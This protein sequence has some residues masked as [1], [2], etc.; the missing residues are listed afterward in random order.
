MVAASTS[1]VKPPTRKI[2]LRVGV[3]SVNGLHYAVVLD[4]FGSTSSKR[5][6]SSGASACAW[7]PRT[8]KPVHFWILDDS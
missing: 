7:N 1:P 6:A 5:T 3:S 4:F 8:D 2:L